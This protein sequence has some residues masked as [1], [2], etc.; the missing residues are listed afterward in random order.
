MCGELKSEELSSFNVGM[1]AKLSDVF[2]GSMQTRGAQ[3]RHQSWDK[4][5]REALARMNRVYKR[6]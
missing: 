6:Q 1:T 5:V 4:K 3:L 2:S